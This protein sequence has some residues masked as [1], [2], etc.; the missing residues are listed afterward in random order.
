[1][2]AVYRESMGKGRRVWTWLVVGTSLLGL[3]V[4]GP[5]LPTAAGTGALVAADGKAAPLIAWPVPPQVTAEI[6]GAVEEA[7]RRFEARDVGGVLAR[8]SDQ[9]RSSGFTK[10]S[11]RE[12]LVTMF[13]VHEELRA[14]LAV[15][16]VESVNGQIWFYTTGAV[17][18]RMPV[19][20][21]VTILT[22][23]RQPE[24]ARREA[25]GWRLIGFQD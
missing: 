2:L 13:A 1:M 6:Q 21:W 15:D 7:R 5:V 22:W 19:L 12:Q 23:Q 4:D 18:G 25:S 17:S 9:Y 10:A 14:R 16:Q 24:V 3:G 8:V 20:G 11:L